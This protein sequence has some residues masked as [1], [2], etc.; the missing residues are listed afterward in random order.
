MKVFNLF[1]KFKTSEINANFAELDGRTSN[2]NNTADA[3]KKVLSATKLTTAR[4]LMLAGD[5]TG[6][7]STDSSTNPSITTTSRKI[8]FVGS[9]AADSNGWY[10]VAEQTMG[11]HGNTNITFMV[12]S[13]YTNYYYG[14]LELQIR[15]DTPY[16]NCTSF[17]WMT[18]KGFVNG[19]FIIVINGMKW[20][21]YVKQN[22][23][24]YGRIYFEILSMS[25]VSSKNM[26]WSLIFEDNLIKE[27][28]IPTPTVVSTENSIVGY[29][30]KLTTARTISLTGDVTGSV[31]FDG[32]ANVSIATTEFLQSETPT[33]SNLGTITTHTAIRKGGVGR[34]KLEALSGNWTANTSYTLCTISS[35]YRPT[36]K[37]KKTICLKDGVFGILEINTNGTVTI[38]PFTS[39]NGLSI[40]IDETYTI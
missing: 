36:I 5:V 25:D 29:S 26:S 2:I 6:N 33:A 7:V 11:A 14:I 17:D 39:I 18:K 4:T 3:T 15:S 20:S 10:K 24:R 38:Y 34:Y 37:I 30:N 31:S 8:A 9:D 13:T 1:D 19:D 40:Q 22:S 23:T 16:T 21:M 27:T 32:S 12:T 28:I 35:N